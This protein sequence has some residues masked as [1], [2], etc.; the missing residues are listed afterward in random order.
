MNH[1]QA[2]FKGA[3]SVRKE[4]PTFDEIMRQPWKYPQG[5]IPEEEG[6]WIACT[7]QEHLM[8]FGAWLAVASIPIGVLYWIFQ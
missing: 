2:A 4:E 3:A 5:R 8:F 7:W 1:E 6:E